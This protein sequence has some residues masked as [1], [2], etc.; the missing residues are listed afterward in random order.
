MPENQDEWF[1]DEATGIRIARDLSDRMAKVDRIV[2]N[3]W[4]PNK[5]DGFMR[6]RLKRSIEGDG[7]NTPIIVRP[8]KR[9]DVDADW[10]IVDGE[11]RWTIAKEELGMSA[12]PIV[13]IGAVTDEQAKAITIKANT[14]KGE[15]D[16]I[17]LAEIIRDLTNATSLVDVAEELPFTAERLQGMMDLLETD[18]EGLDLSMPGI[19][20]GDD[21][22][23][24]EEP[25]KERA[26]SNDEFK[27]FDPSE[28]QF[29]HK[30]PR[31]GFEYNDKAES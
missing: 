10:E 17:G 14:L 6:T 22:G 28:Q 29:A 26:K 18:M 5:M 2:S 27:S 4:N 19:G 12:V 23:G 31:C 21:E 8:C 3:K 16:S 24:G 30:C 13:N 7:F 20:G 1:V 15:F 11:Q 25:P 9:D